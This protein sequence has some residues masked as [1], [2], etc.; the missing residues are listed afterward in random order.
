[1]SVPEPYFVHE[2]DDFRVE[3]LVGM[4]DPRTVDDTDVVVRLLPSGARYSATVMT[5]EVI[6]RIMDRHAK[7]GESLDGRF[8]QIP[9]LLI[10]RGSGVEEIVD[11]IRHMVRTD[12]VDG[13]LPRLP[14]DE[15]DE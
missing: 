4:D 2:E 5:I 6:Q 3:V 12:D 7:T 11:V 1:M 8:F 10:L 15:G 9:D 13:M 14:D